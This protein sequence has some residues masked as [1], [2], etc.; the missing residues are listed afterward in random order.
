MH[1]HMDMCMTYMHMHMCMHMCMCNMCMYVYVCSALVPHGLQCLMGYR[2]PLPSAPRAIGP[3][4]LVPNGLFGAKRLR[5]L[6]CA[7]GHAPAAEA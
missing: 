5:L 7:A 6:A 1:M 4:E 3:H 2:A